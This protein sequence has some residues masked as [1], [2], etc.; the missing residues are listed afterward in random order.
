MLLLIDNY[1]SF[2]YNLV[3]YF[4]ILKQDVIV[5]SNDKLCLNDIKK[6]NPEYIVISPG[7]NGPEDSGICIEVIKQF[8]T[9]IPILGICLGHQCIASAFGGQI[10]H[11]G[12]IYHGKTTAIEHNG[13][14]L[15]KEIP[16]PFA[17]TRYHSLAIEKQEL[18]DCFTI[19]ATSGGTVMAISHKKYPLYGVQ[20]HPEA[21]LTEHGIDLLQN[22]LDCQDSIT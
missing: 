12:S 10:S 3:Q 7:P 4:K 14:N 21:I 9:T 15:F 5:E 8:Y 18:A 22:F 2:T 20:F 6:L 19:D 13:E 1:D 11:A 16:S 17:A